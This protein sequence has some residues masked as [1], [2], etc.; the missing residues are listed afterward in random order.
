MT[1]ANYLIYLAKQINLK[2]IQ[3][4]QIFYEL[5]KLVEV[6]RK[7]WISTLARVIRQMKKLMGKIDV[8]ESRNWEA[9]ENSLVH[10]AFQKFLFVN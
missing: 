10:K 4:K 8:Y 5:T 9:V 6:K 7:P 1:I 2:V 3:E